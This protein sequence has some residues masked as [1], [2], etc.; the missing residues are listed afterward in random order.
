MNK[1]DTAL[2]TPDDIDIGYRPYQV[3]A[4]WNLF[5]ATGGITSTATSVTT[6]ANYFPGGNP[7]A[8]TFPAQQV[9]FSRFL[10]SGYST[11]YIGAINVSVCTSTIIAL[12]LTTLF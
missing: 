1:A 10:A 3:G 7:S 8:S 2:T 4:G 11:T 9:D 5:K 6:S 12:A